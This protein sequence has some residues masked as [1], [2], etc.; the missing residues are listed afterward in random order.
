MINDVLVFHYAALTSLS[1]EAVS[2]FA[3]NL[4]TYCLVNNAVKDNPSIEKCITE[5]KTGLSFKRKLS[6]VQEHCQKLLNSF[7]AVG[8]SYA[9]IAI[10]LGEDWI[11]AIGNELGFDFNIDIDD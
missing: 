9:N 10:A 2:D 1:M 8:G 11:E 7:F 4:F 3:N 6:Q 5:F